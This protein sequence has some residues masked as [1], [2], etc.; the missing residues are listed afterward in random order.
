MAE[1]KNRQLELYDRY[2]EANFTDRNLP[3]FTPDRRDF[4]KTLGAGILILLALPGEAVA[5]Q[6]EVGGRRFD[7]HP[8]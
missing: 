8:E 4:V 1:E 5:Q 7:G 2:L 6:D 3:D